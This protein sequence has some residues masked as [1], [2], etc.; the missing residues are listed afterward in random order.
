MLRLIKLATYGILAYAI[1]EFV[2]GVRTG[3][4]Q[5]QGGSRPGGGFGALGMGQRQ[6]QAGSQAQPQ[7]SGM[8]DARSPLLGTENPQGM[9]VVTADPDGSSTSEIVGRGVVSR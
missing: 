2:Q 1:Y 7:D 6:Q 5:R 9:R 8:G 4:T 3:Q